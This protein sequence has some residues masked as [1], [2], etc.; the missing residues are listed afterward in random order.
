MSQLRSLSQ[1][2]SLGLLW[3]AIALTMAFTPL[4]PLPYAPYSTSSIGSLTALGG[5]YLSEKVI[6]KIRER[7]AKAELML[8]HYQQLRDTVFANWAKANIIPTDHFNL[9]GFR[10]TT[11]SPMFFA[12]DVEEKMDERSLQR[13]Y[14]HLK[15]PKYAENFEGYREAHKVISDHNMR[16]KN[17]AEE[18]EQDVKLLL[19]RYPM[20]SES[21]RQKTGWYQ[22][23]EI[24]RAIETTTG[25]ELVV[26]VGNEVYSEDFGGEGRPLANVSDNLLRSLFLGEVRSLKAKYLSRVSG[27]LDDALTAD[28]SLTGFRAFM[29]EVVRT[30]TELETLEGSCEVELGKISAW[31]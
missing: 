3:V 1:K 31:P 29:I 15:S 27:L 20:L 8:R 9:A 2:L 25:A 5:F 18:I 14:D 19:L 10:M 23:R 11:A 28:A 16:A 22:R 13:A 26:E 7:P 6:D 21:E 12:I 17:L 30:I 24:E 4:L